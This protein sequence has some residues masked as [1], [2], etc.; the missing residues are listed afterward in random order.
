MNK[1][2]KRPNIPPPAPILPTEKPEGS[3]SSFHIDKEPSE[4]SK[5]LKE[6][7]RVGFLDPVCAPLV[8][9][10]NRAL[11]WAVKRLSAYNAKRGRS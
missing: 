7:F 5:A 9:R 4:L 1:S 6:L 8:K 3:T 2:V 11:L 10:I